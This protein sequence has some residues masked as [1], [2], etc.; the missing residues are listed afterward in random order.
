M[1]KSHDP[2]MQQKREELARFL[3][4]D[5]TSL[6]ISFGN[7]KNLLA[8]YDQLGHVQDGFYIYRLY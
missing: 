4:V 2:V 7:Q 3:G 8:D 6:R 5:K 1:H